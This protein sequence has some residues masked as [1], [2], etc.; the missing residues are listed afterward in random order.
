MT[1]KP[2]ISENSKSLSPAS[3]KDG[4]VPARQLALAV[5]ERVLKHKQTI[6]EAFIKFPPTEDMASRDRAFAR[7]LVITVLQRLGQLDLIIEPMLDRPIG[8]LRPTA[9]LDVLRLGTAQLLFLE[10]ASHAA[11]NTSVLLA[12]AEGMARQKGLVNAVMRRIGREGIALLNKQDQTRINVP[13]WLWKS[14]VEDYGEEVAHQIAEANL[15]LPSLDVTVKLDPMVWAEKLNAKLLANGSLR[16]AEGG[17]VPELPGFDDGVWWVQNAVSSLPATLFGEIRG[18][19]IVDMCA[20]PGGKTAQLASQGARVV[21]LDRSAKRL[22]RLHEN[23][24]R[25][26][27]SVDTHVVDGAAWS[28]K[29]G[30]LVDGI[31]LDA[32]CSATGTIRH[33]PDVS[34]LKSPQDVTKLVAVQRRL[35]ENA[36]QYVKPGG[37]LIYCTCSLQ[38]AEGEDQID[39]FMDKF[40]GQFEQTVILPSEVGGWDMLLNEHG[41]VR[42]LPFHLAAQ[43]GFDG[44][45]IARLIRI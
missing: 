13:D 24:E 30:H 23:M 43:G 33:Q 1:N 4:G 7:I 18:K 29:E 28:P 16:L 31:L 40:Q 14:W 38:K 21:A 27:F 5:I 6:D 20:A 36:S 25:L 37:Y 3:E 34:H 12:E 19:E 26:N 2:V 22:V 41:Q 35:L 11:V 42:A 32:P 17:N 10:T 44:F 45:F 8:R 39:W 15:S 9:I